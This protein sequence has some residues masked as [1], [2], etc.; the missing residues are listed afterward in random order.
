MTCIHYS[1][2]SRVFT[3]PLPSPSKSQTPRGPGV[4]QEEGPAYSSLIHFLMLQ[5]L[6]CG[7]QV[8]RQVF[9]KK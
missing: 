8:C 9:K 5:E 3:A 6:T 2:S 7:D 4:G 1:V